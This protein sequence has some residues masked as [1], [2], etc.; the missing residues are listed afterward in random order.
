MTGR[1]IEDVI[2][3]LRAHDDTSTAYKRERAQQDR[4][5]RLAE[6]VGVLERQVATLFRRMPKW[7]QIGR[8]S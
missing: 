3:P 5:E 6:K 1:K 7:E 2:P 4:L 8:R